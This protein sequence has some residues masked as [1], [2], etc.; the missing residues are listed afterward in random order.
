MIAEKTDSQVAEPADGLP[1]PRRLWA[2]MAA[3]LALIMSVIDGTIVNVALPTL[4]DQFGVSPSSA[5]WIVNAYQLVI[6]ISL[7]SFSLLGDIYGYRRIF[8]S[9]IVAFGVSSLACALSRSFW[10]LTAARVLQGFGASAIT[11]VNTAQL[12]T[13]YPR[14][15][16]GRGLSIN[17]MIVAVSIAAGPSLASAILSVGTWPWLFALNVP[18]AVAAWVMGY[19][20]LPKKEERIQARFDK[21]SAV[22]NALTFG[23]LIYTLEG[24][25][26]H[27]NRLY[28]VVQLLLLL[29]VGTFYVRRQL[30]M[31][32]PMLPFDLM[33]IPIFSLSVLTSV[34]SFTAQ[35]LAMV[36]LPFFFQ[37]TL[38]RSAVEIGLLLTPWP[39][40]TLVTAPVAG[41]L[42]E[43]IHPGILGSIGMAI[44]AAGLGLLAALPDAPTNLDIV[45]RL[46]LCGMGFGLFQTPNNTT[47]ISSAPL[48]RSGSAS[49][50]LGMARLLGQ[51]LGT[52]LVALLFGMVVQER[53][54]HVCLL[55]GVAFAVVAGIV[56]SLRLSQ[57][58]PL[59]N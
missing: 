46:L 27:E 24:V 52:T 44:F 30:R 41:I 29:A 9:G 33:R 15:Q 10:M 58:A 26:H 56:S 5:I 17:A 20:F 22:A 42:V 45:W 40:A 39:I 51:T 23:L 47:L 13:I 49:G 18:L 53:S 7:L 54:T 16:I 32:N 3:A 14:R 37:N 50:M 28:V 36:S 31:E 8:L 43:R 34:C 48:N 12:R 38:G 2:V 1:L 19:R 59:R 21:V 35:M 25:A 4:A 11:S 6:T 57:A 55:C